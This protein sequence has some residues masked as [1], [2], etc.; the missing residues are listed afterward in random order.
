[1]VSGNLVSL[2]SGSLTIL[3]ALLM[4]VIRI[5][6]CPYVSSM[7]VLVTNNLRNVLHHRIQLDSQLVDQALQWLKAGAEET[8]REDVRVL[9]D[10]CVDIVQRVER[11]RAAPNVGVCSRI[12]L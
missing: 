2:V 12:L 1:M 8:Q 9:R 10:I 4:V 5:V 3:Y 6:S 7:M 11:K